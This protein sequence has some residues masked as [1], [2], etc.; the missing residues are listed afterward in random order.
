[1]LIII[2]LNSIFLLIFAILNKEMIINENKYLNL[3][4]TVINKT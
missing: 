4:K 3:K 1:M 2:L